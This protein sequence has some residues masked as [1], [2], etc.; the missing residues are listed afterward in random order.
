M[1]LGGVCLVAGRVW[2]ALER[3]RAAAVAAREQSEKRAAIRNILKLDSARLEGFIYDNSYWDDMAKFVSRPDPGWGKENIAVSLPTFGGSAAWVYDPSMKLVYHA[4]A[5]GGP[6]SLPGIS[7][8]A[9]RRAFSGNEHFVAFYVRQ[10]AN[11]LEVRGATIHLTADDKRTGRVFGYLLACRTWDRARLK[12]LGEE[13]GA[14]AS[15]AGTREPDPHVAGDRGGAYRVRVAEDLVGVRG[16]VVAHLVFDVKLPI[17]RLYDT[18]MVRMQQYL[19]IV[20]VFLIAVLAW[21]LVAWVKA[22]LDTIGRALERNDPACLVRLSNTKTEFGTLAGMVLDSF[23]REE[24]LA[25]RT[26]CLEEAILTRDEAERS[27][28]LTQFT[29]DHAA[30][31]IFW[32]ERSG[33]VIYVNE[34]AC[35]LFGGTAHELESLN[36]YDFDTTLTPD[37]LEHTLSQLDETETL[38]LERQ[39]RTRRGTTLPVEILLTRARFEGR[40]VYCGFAR[41]VTERNRAQSEL[42]RAR[43]AAEE[44]AQAKGQ[45]LANMSH[46][47]RTPMNAVIGMTELLLKTGL[48][49]VQRDYVETVQRSGEALLSIVNDILDFSKIEAGR[50]DIATGSVDLGIIVE[51]VAELVAPACA[52]K[53]VEVIAR[54]APDVPGDLQGDRMHIQQIL[55]NLAGNAAKFTDAGEVVVSAEALRETDG[56]VTVRLSVRDTGIGIDPSK[57][58]AIFDSFAQADSGTSRRFGGTGLGLTISR[59]LAQLMGGSIGL[60]SEE[61]KGSTFW[62]DLPLAQDNPAGVPEERP[63]LSGRTIVVADSNASVRSAIAGHLEA[64][65]ASVVTASSRAEIAAAASSRTALMLVAADIAGAPG[66]ASPAEGYHGVPVVVL[67]HLGEPAAW[68][69]ASAAVLRKPVRRQALQSVVMQALGLVSADAASVE[70]EACSPDAAGLVGL[71]VLV[72]EDNAVNRKVATRM[73]ESLGCETLVAVNGQEG[74]A[75]C[76]AERPDIVLMDCQMPVMDGYDATRAIRLHEASAGG[77]APIIAMTANTMPGDRD[78]CIEC[79]MDDYVGKP[80]KSDQLRDVLLAWVR[81]P[82]DERRKAA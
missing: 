63:D 48:T 40:E 46:E 22:P 62:V 77:H 33:R 11:V 1:S 58:A 19:T 73:L 43:D 42:A 3:Q 69:G 28:R 30:D 60:D 13:V 75:R 14:E 61:G 20:V 74:V 66:D 51:E 34:S 2:L 17:L 55:L 24:Q 8:A 26:A 15:L 47:I 29:V 79:G 21:C 45:F 23:A 9:I 38:M 6:A 4:H 5:P 71:R 49:D 50:L 76:V 82:E 70:T 32:I 27:L 81:P 65:G 35:R 36:A 59:R 18:S 56:I 52:A 80:F 78:R 72:V 12:R 7:E 31:V 25:E 53:A 64:W 41:D 67:A 37:V 68:S 39:Y 54:V 57:H 44:A 16:S 10:G